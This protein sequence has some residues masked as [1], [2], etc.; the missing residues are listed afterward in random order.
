MILRIKSKYIIWL[1]LFIVAVGGIVNSIIKSNYI[2]YMVDALNI[3]LIFFCLDKLGR[4]RKIKYSKIV[5]IIVSLLFIEACA[6][7]IINFVPTKLVLWGIRTEFRFFAFFLICIIVLKTKDIMQILDMACKFYWINFCFIMFQYFILKLKGD[8]L[9]GLF[10]TE[11]GCNGSSIIFLNLIIAYIVAQYIYKKIT[12]LHAIPYV[13][14]YFIITALSETKGNFIFFIFIIIAEV[15]V[16]KKNIRTII[17]IVLTIGALICGYF[18]IIKVFPESKDILLSFTN[19]NE[20]MDASYLGK[21]T[22]T[23]NA[24]Y[25][26]SNIFLNSNLK[27]VLGLGIGAC[28]TSKFFVSDFY[29]KYGDMNYRQYSAAI[30]VLQNGYLGTILYFSFFASVIY[31]AFKYMKKLDVENKIVCVT[32][33]GY[34]IF[35]VID[36]IYASLFIDAGY[37]GWLVM[38]MPLIIAK[39]C[40][41]KK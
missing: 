24:L 29:M 25:S 32:A 39:D 11:K 7:A 30:V 38:A 20:Y 2:Y 21:K 13:F 1:M 17:T 6:G 36:N 4:F 33:I 15:I 27:K 37:I 14:T 26:T 9:G 28:E 41:C 34:I 16:C 12:L 23:R 3:F 22:F 10:G 18:I 19:A 35:L 31:M 40:V 5:L 8:Y